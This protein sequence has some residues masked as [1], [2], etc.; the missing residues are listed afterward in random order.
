MSL[1]PP[2]L[3]LA[4]TT[5]FTLVSYGIFGF[6]GVFVAGAIAFMVCSWSYWGADVA[7]LR[8]AEARRVEC[9]QEP[10]LIATVAELAK[11]SGVP[12]PI[13]YTVVDRQPN[14][15]ALGRTP[16]HASLVLSSG[17]LG[18]LKQDEL[19]AVIAH[20]LAHIRR[21]D[22]LTMTFAATLVGGTV[23]IGA[24]L[25]LVALV[26]GNRSAGRG[27]LI[28]LA[29]SAPLAAII[30]RCGLGR[31]LEYDA[32]RTSA[33]LCGGPEPLIRALQK[34]DK[35]SHEAPSA[36]ALARPQMACL[37]I[38]HPFPNLRLT[39]LFA[40]HPTTEARIDRLRRLWG[41]QSKPPSLCRAAI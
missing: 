19:E 36:T 41:S 15:F 29:V 25:G 23:L 39:W 9:A 7:I 13:V 33:I 22:T 21:R 27:T 30:L 6:D 1:K 14:A 11:K 16:P 18:S 37:Y 26:L 28:A 10:E 3:L 17:L 5:L 12:P 34:L 2:L 20:E 4:L 40:S 32:D 8:A 31:Q 38:V 24:A 35:A